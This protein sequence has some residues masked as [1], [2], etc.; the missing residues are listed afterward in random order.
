MKHPLLPV[1]VLFL[2]LS[3]ITLTG[4][5]SEKDPVPST[6]TVSNAS[7]GSAAS[8]GSSGSTAAETASFTQGLATTTVKE[9]FACKGARVTS[10]GEIQSDDG[11]KWT[12]PADIDTKLTDAADL[13]NPCKNVN[14]PNVASVDL[15]KVPVVEI[16][17]NGTVVTGYIFADNYF[18]LYINGKP[19][20]K[21]AVPFTPFNSHVVRF[22]ASYPM[23]Y[24]MKVVDW[25]E[26]LGLGTEANKGNPY[27]PGDAGV[28]AVFSDGTV[29]DGSWKAQ[30]YYIAPLASKTDLVLETRNGVQLRTTP[31][32]SNSPSCAKSCYA[33]HFAV[34]DQ[35]FAK[36]FNDAAWP[37]ATVY[38]TADVG[39]D[40]K[41][42]YTNY[43]SEFGKGS[44]I[45]SSNLV[46]DN[47]VL[48]RRTVDKAPATK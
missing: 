26:N 40:N 25:E 8:A 46:L 21:D 9:L 39:V 24:A 15:S 10:L 23:T 2:A 4:C 17:P 47:E 41:S 45:W 37:S 36:T 35:W 16:D 44:F 11:K 28:V 18:E 30:T 32:A 43:K 1:G 33:A 22:K 42:E 6:S 29:T 38:K 27:H 31:N 48:L 3:V 7:P 14:L 12:V 13:S 5:S 19:V 20:A 34:P